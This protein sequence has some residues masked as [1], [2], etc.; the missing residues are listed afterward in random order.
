M[1]AEPG[2]VSSPCSQARRKAGQRDTL[3]DSELG[4]S[5]RPTLRPEYSLHRQ[6][7]VCALALKT[8]TMQLLSQALGHTCGLLWRVGFHRHPGRLARGGEGPGPSEAAGWEQAGLCD[9][10]GEDV[11]A[12][13][14]YVLLSLGRDGLRGSR[15]VPAGLLCAPPARA[16]SVT[17]VALSAPSPGMPSSSG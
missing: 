15:E 11:S 17:R 3:P 7:L 2:P 16:R 9:Q 1:K 13:L 6:V 8:N 4:V 10:P 14:R 12:H 5:E